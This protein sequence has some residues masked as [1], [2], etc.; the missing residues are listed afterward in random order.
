MQYTLSAP[1]TCGPLDPVRLARV[2]SALEPGVSVPTLAGPTH[3]PL[4]A[5]PALFAAI[6]DPR[7]A[8]GRRFPLPAV[9]AAVL[10]ALLSNHRSQLAA[11]EWLADQAP[12]AQ[13]A[14]GFSPTHGTPHQ[15]T[16]NRLLARL[17]PTYLATALHQFLDPPTADPRPRGSQGVALDGKAQRG[18]L[19]FTPPAPGVSAIHEVAAYTHDTGTVLAAVPVTSTANKPAAEL[20]TAPQLLV[21]VDWRGRV[22]TGDALWCQCNLCAA[23]VEADGDYLVTVKANQGHLLDCLQR[24]FAPTRPRAH[25]WAPVAVE[26]RET[27]T[28]ERAQ[29]RYEVRFLAATAELAGVL[30]WPHLAQAFMVIRS[31]EAHGQV[32]QEIHWGVTSLPA[33]VADMERLLELRRGHWRIENGLH[34]VKDVTL[35]EDASLVHRGQGPAVMSLLRDGVVSLLHAA[36]HQQIAARLR[37]HSRHPEAALALLGITLAENA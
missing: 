23:V 15:S 2:L 28:C 13:R 4:R 14:L 34:Y 16:I 24:W 25:G 36:G 1:L 21:Q 31:W 37:Y 12:T 35:G 18:R 6:P 10:A 5:L 29:G 7:T 33:T 26:Q 17:E 22:L 30:D 9:L 20:N 11:A 32:H 3:V 19:R 27:A 8:K